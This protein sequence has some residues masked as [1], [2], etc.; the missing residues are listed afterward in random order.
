M[1]TSLAVCSGLCPVGQ[2]SVTGSVACTPCPVGQYGASLGLT[3]AACSGACVLSSG[4]SCP[5][6]STSAGG[7]QCPAGS[8]MPSVS[9][10][11]ALCPAGRYG[12]TAGLTSSLCSSTCTAVPGRYCGAGATDASGIACPSGSTSTGGSVTS[13]TLCPAG[14]YS[15]V[16]GSPAC[17][18]VCNA[19]VGSYCEVGM[20]SSTQLVPC[21]PG[22]YNN[23][24][25]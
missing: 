5:A 22:T 9:S 25:Y 12:S 13:C 23:R 2:F 3:S 20:A 1:A 11:C 7:V 4:Y 10:P 15:D 14:T 6:G 8:Y 18:G 17:A 16:A 21:P 19:T 24:T